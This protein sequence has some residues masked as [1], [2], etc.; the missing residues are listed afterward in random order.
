VEEEG[1]ILHFVRSRHI[2]GESWDIVLLQIAV[3][4]LSRILSEANNIK[5]FF[6]HDGDIILLFPQ[7]SD[8]IVSRAQD[9]IQDTFKCSTKDSHIYD[10]LDDITKVT[11]ICNKKNDVWQVWKNK[12]KSQANSQV[13]VK[14]DEKYAKQLL[15]KRK[16]RKGTHILLVEDEPFTLKLI[17]GILEGNTIIKATNGPDAVE[18]Y[19]LNAPDIVFLDI[20]LPGIDGHKVLEHIFSFDPDC[21]VV[22]L[23]GNTLMKDVSYALSKGAQG[24][25]VKPFP[26]E[27]LL[28][29]VGLYKSIKD[30]KSCIN[31]AV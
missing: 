31:E 25:V 20:N 12:N 26:K 3:A 2:Y 6:M 22:M 14:I 7:A 17:E 27:K 13:K 11:N 29:Y 10:F 1:S 28:N 19:M 5:S 30:E 23:S 9:F 4:G 21:Y 16:T 18:S 8:E 24:F 15:E